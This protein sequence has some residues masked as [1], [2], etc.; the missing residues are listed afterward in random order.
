MNKIVITR[1]MMGICGMQVCAE[2]DTTDEEIL[3]FCNRENEAGTTNGWTTVIRTGNEFE[4]TN[5]ESKPV[6]CDEHPERLHF[7]VYC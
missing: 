5:D 7:L 6:K 1:R 4:M 2:A 3:E